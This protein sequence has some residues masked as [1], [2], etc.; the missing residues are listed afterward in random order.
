MS[1][2][3]YNCILTPEELETKLNE[4]IAYCERENT[5]PSDYILIDVIGVSEHTIERYFEYADVVIPEDVTE[6]EKAIIVKKKELGEKIKKLLRYREHY[7]QKLMIDKPNAQSGA[8]FAL[9]QVKNG[10]WTDKTDKKD[11]VTITVKLGK[12]DA[13]EAFG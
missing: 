12:I 10:G 1:T 5:P 8:I 13:S 6:E 2:K 7:Y 9:K 4:F 3:A 11:D